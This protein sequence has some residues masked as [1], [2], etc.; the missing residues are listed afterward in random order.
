MRNQRDTVFYINAN[1]LQHFQICF[2][3][4]LKLFIVNVLDIQL[5]PLQ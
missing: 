5:N 1:V 2:G 3:V 4:P